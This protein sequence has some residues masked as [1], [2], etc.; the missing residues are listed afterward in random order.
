MLLFPSRFSLISLG[1]FPTDNLDTYSKIQDNDITDDASSA[2]SINAISREVRSPPHDITAKH[3]LRRTV[4]AAQTGVGARTT[5]KLAGKD[6]A[7][8]SVSEGIDSPQ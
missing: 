8:A 4:E 7:D 3:V 2:I 6:D 5:S 1:S